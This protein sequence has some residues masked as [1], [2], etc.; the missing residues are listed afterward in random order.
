MSC[1]RK[2]FLRWKKVNPKELWEEYSKGKLTYQQLAE[3][4]NCTKRTIQRKIDL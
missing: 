4:Y 1:L 3:K 2:T